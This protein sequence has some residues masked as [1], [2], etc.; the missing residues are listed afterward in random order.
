MSYFIISYHYH[1]MPYHNTSYHITSF[2]IAPAPKPSSGSGS[3]LRRLLQTPGTCSLSGQF[4]ELRRAGRARRVLGG[5]AAG[6]RGPSPAGQGPAGTAWQRTRIL[7]RSCRAAALSGAVTQASGASAPIR[8][9]FHVLLVLP[10]RPSSDSDVRTDRG[11][12]AAAAPPPRRCSE[13]PRRCSAPA[14]QMARPRPPRAVRTAAGPA[15]SPSRRSLFRSKED[16]G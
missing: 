7:P 9:N 1:I 4:A 10:S 14:P 2:Y 13:A 12:L 5:A 16:R 15:P 11:S 6:G 3:W 8:K